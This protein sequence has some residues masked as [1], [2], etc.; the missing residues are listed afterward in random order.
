[1]IALTLSETKAGAELRVVSEKKIK[2]GGILRL[3]VEM[4]IVA[5]VVSD[6]TT[7]LSIR[8]GLKSVTR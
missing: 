5:V 7:T 1:L 4:N 3:I 2:I 6:E 8:I